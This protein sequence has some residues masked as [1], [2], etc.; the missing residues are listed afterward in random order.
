[1]NAKPLSAP[2]LALGMRPCAS[3]ATHESPKRHNDTHYRHMSC[4][5]RRSDG[6]RAQQRISA[7]HIAAI[8][9][10]C[11]TRRSSHTDSIVHIHSTA[12]LQPSESAEPPI[13]CTLHQQASTDSKDAPAARSRQLDS[14]P[15]SAHATPR[16]MLNSCLAPD[17]GCAGL[18]HSPLVAWP[19]P[20]TMSRF[21]CSSSWS[22][23]SYAAAAR[24]R[25]D[26]TC[27][28]HEG[29][30][31]SA[32]RPTF[33]VGSSRGRAP[34][35]AECPRPVHEQCG[36][37]LRQRGVPSSNIVIRYFHAHTP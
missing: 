12:S 16:S 27:R 21:R 25:C 37:L 33:H 31:N 1:M 18:Q 7:Q 13:G 11:A 4:G 6:V 23:S 28:N 15:R 3:D 35:R 22:R 36:R 19:Q 5:G 29:T 26:F 9:A 17:G 14:V 24:R 30:Q 10:A 20:G 32:V 34:D 2:Y 8:T